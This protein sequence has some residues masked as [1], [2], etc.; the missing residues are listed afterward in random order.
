MEKVNPRCS[1][2]HGITIYENY[3][4]HEWGQPVLDEQ[5]MFEFLLLETFQAGLSWITVLKKR[6]DFRQVFHDFNPERVAQMSSA[7]IEAA[8]HNP[9]IIRNKAKILAAIHNAQLV[10]E[11]HEQGNSLVDFFWS[12]VDY[13]PIQND[14]ES[15]SDIPAKTSIAEDISKALKKMGFKF[16][17]PTVIYAHMQATGMV[18]DHITSCPSHPVVRALGKDLK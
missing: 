5:K 1:W 4:D 12:K 9:R 14:F 10:T 2:C 18:N 7:E 6:E 15:M 8:L 17:G 11:M 3:H 16:V 13:T